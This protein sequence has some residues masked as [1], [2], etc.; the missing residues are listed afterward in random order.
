ME[1]VNELVMPPMQLSICLIKYY[2]GQTD[3][4]LS[5]RK[6]DSWWLFLRLAYIFQV[7]KVNHIL[8]LEIFVNIESSFYQKVIAEKKLFCVKLKERMSLPT[9]VLL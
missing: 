3:I 7:P 5:Y 6:H 2:L 9:C 4:H 1:V 8:R